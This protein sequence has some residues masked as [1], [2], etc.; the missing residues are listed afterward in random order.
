MIS[1]MSQRVTVL[2]HTPDPPSCANDSEKTIV[3]PK[4]YPKS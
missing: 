2:M 4:F 3:I 1:V